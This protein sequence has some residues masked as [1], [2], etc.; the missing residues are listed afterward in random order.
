MSLIG[1]CTSAVAVNQACLVW[2]S[3]SKLGSRI[4][5]ANRTK[6][7]TKERGKKVPKYQK[8]KERR[9]KSSEELSEHVPTAQPDGGPP[10][11]LSPSLLSS[12]PL[13]LLSVSPSCARVSS[14]PSVISCVLALVAPTSSPVRTQLAAQLCSEGFSIRE[15]K[16][17]TIFSL[18]QE[19]K[20][21]VQE[22]VQRRTFMKRT[23]SY[24]KRRRRR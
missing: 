14:S 3:V 20:E 22:S 5:E 9:R 4:G 21:K 16:T 2:E 10:G 17:L 6:M 19:C 15:R 13:S 12:L 8:K 23:K 11:C 24:F 18:I 7:M 1:T